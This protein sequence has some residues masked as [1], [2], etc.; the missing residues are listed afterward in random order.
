MFRTGY[1]Q[2]RRT[3]RRSR[4]PRVRL[5]ARFRSEPSR[6]ASQPRAGSISARCDP[7]RTAAARPPFCRHGDGLE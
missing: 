4:R 1:A 5:R 2:R 3:H 6:I 7:I